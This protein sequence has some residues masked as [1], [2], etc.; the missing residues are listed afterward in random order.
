M[1]DAEA[2]ALARLRARD[3]VLEVVNALFVATDDRDWEKVRACFAPRVHFDM[4]SLVG[5]EAA[6]LRAEQIVDGWRQGLQP[7][8]AVH[9][10]IGN[11]RV[12]VDGSAA[13]AFC[14]GIALHYRKTR[15]G[16]DTRTF[17][18]SYDLHLIASDRGWVIDRFRFTLKFVDGNLELEK[19]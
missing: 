16:R 7:I 11:C 12:D 13:T 6:A 15:S 1:T 18:G 2:H 14:Y 3:A 19:D 9:H 10:Q 17:V 5:G 8:T 4:T